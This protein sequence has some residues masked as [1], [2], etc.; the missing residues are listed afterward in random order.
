MV[1]I[2]SNRPALANASS[3]PTEFTGHWNTGGD[4][5][6]ETTI[7]VASSPAHFYVNVIDN[8]FLNRNDELY[9]VQ[10]GTI[11]TMDNG[12][13]RVVT[14][15]SVD[16]VDEWPTYKYYVFG[17][18]EN[19]DDGFNFSNDQLTFVTFENTSELVDEPTLTGI[20][21]DDP[22]VPGGDI[23]LTGI[24]V[25]YAGSSML[26]FEVLVDSVTQS[27]ATNKTA[28]AINIELNNGTHD[29]HLDAGTYVVTVRV[30]RNGQSRWVF[31]HNIN[32]STS[33][34]S[35]GPFTFDQWTD[36]EENAVSSIW[37]LHVPKSYSGTFATLTLEGRTSAPISCDADTTELQAALM[38]DDFTGP[39]PGHEFDGGFLP[40]VSDGGDHWV[41]YMR[42][43]SSTEFNSWLDPGHSASEF[44]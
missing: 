42:F 5:G 41:W 1:V 43:D 14:V 33:G 24:D 18:T 27:S 9:H 36:G 31:S 34:T 37:E 20:P 6:V 38:T 3:G 11:I 21:A 23:F 40:T 19:S 22:D 44:E 35:G 7:D 32:F 13:P 12:E 2:V 25:I 29:F 26:D 15:T 17:I 4:A 30:R 16:D 28:A 39:Y 10:I 8:G